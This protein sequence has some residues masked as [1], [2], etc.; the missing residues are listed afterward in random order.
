LRVFRRGKPHVLQNPP[1]GVGPGKPW[2]DL[3]IRS[4]K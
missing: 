2:H 4:I 1:L 3:E